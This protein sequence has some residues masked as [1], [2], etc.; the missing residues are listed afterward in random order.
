MP[1]GWIDAL[2]LYNVGM[3]SWT[4]PKKGSAQFDALEKVRRGDEHVTIPQ[5]KPK[6]LE[7]IVPS[8]FKIDVDEVRLAL[9]HWFA[10]RKSM[11]TYPKGSTTFGE[12]FTDV[13][14]AESQLKKLPVTLPSLPS[15]EAGN[16]PAV[17][18]WVSGT[19][20]G[21]EVIF[22]IVGD[23]V[24]RLAF[25]GDASGFVRRTEEALKGPLTFRVY[26]T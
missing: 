15:H 24:Y 12:T 7:T 3:N 16:S 25:E 6:R 26:R 2:R 9:M 18:W 21:K 8:K 13:K 22:E 17:R 4:I 1:V 20:E 23:V 10:Q 14:R 5:D 19:S 11:K